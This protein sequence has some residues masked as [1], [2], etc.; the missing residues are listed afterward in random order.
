MNEVDNFENILEQINKKINTAGK[1][2]R[3][4]SLEIKYRGKKLTPHEEVK[5]LELL[6]EKSGAEIKGIMED[7]DFKEN[8]V[9]IKSIEIKTEVFAENKT[10]VNPEHDDEGITKF[11]KGTIRSGRLINYKGNVVIMG[12]VNPG[13][14]II[15]SGN[16]IVLGSLRGIVHAGAEGNKEAVIVA[17]NLHPTQI[18]IADVI[19]R[20]PDGKGSKSQYIPEMARVKDNTIIIDRYL[21]QK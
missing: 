9:P 21:Q 8:M 6:E 20:A 2:F 11:F 5:I 12:D 4:A 19:T 17:L 3:G 10:I 1:F 14:E 18:R 13:G 15:A 16:V 7:F